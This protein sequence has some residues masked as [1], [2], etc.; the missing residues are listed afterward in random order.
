MRQ[1]GWR[2]TL[3]RQFAWRLLTKEKPMA[4]SLPNSP[5]NAALNTAK[6]AANLALIPSLFSVLPQNVSLII[7]VAMITCAG[8]TASV[9]APVHNRL[10]IGLYQLVRIGGLGIRYAIPYVATHLVKGASGPTDAPS[11]DTQASATVATISK[12]TAK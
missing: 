10:L 9:P 4:E 12:D 1:Q 11:A 8:I 5:P 3:L 7:C 6:V 2:L